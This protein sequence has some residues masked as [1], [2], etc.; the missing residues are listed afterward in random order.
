MSKSNSENGFLNK[1]QTFFRGNKEEHQPRNETPRSQQNIVYQSFST[2]NIIY[3]NP[4]SQNIIYQ[5]QPYHNRMSSKGPCDAG[6][7]NRVAGI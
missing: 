1:L 7:T 6:P 3:Q 5:T 4:N 2:Q